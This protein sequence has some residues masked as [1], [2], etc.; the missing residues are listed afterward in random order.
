ML[1]IA[2]EWKLNSRLQN[3]ENNILDCYTMPPL[4]PLGSPWRQ[5]SPNPSPSSRCEPGVKGEKQKGW[6][7]HML[8]MIMRH[9]VTS[10]V[11]GRPF[12]D[13]QSYIPVYP[14]HL[15]GYF[16]L[17]VI[18]DV[19]LLRVGGDTCVGKQLTFSH[20]KP[21]VSQQSGSQKWLVYHHESDDL[22]GPP[23]WYDVSNILK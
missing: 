2:C 12:V 20:H 23:W 8:G 9:W 22:G 6:L 5:P 15:I 16:A 10:G 3:A 11:I 19:V 18:N 21:G 1:Q 17:G 14:A 7:I 4:S 13:S